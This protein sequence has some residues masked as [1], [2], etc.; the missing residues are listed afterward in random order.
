MRKFHEKPPTRKN[1]VTKRQICHKTKAQGRCYRS[2]NY[3]I[4]LLLVM[5]GKFSYLEPPKNETHVKYEKVRVQ[6]LEFHG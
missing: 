1:G 5:M 2:L 6:D 3:L 4:F